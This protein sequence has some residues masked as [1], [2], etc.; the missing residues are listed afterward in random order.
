M[1][2]LST[3]TKYPPKNSTSK[4]PP[5]NDKLQL[6]NKT[7]NSLYCDDEKRHMAARILHLDYEEKRRV[8]RRLREETMRAMQQVDDHDDEE[9][10]DFDL[11]GVQDDAFVGVY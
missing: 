6:H 9:D 5:K 3:I 10:D 1:V 7:T 2:P 11:Q 4:Y 8:A